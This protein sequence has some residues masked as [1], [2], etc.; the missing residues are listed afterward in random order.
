MTDWR[1]NKSSRLEPRPSVS[2]AESAGDAGRFSC[3]PRCAIGS[4]R[5]PETFGD[6]MSPMI[7]NV[8]R[9]PLFNLA[10]VATVLTFLGLTAGWVRS[11]SIRDSVEYCRLGGGRF[12][13]WSGDGRV[14]LWLQHYDWSKRPDVIVPHIVKSSEPCKSVSEESAR[15]AFLGFGFDS[16]LE[17]TGIGYRYVLVPYWFLAGASLLLSVCIAR[18]SPPLDGRTSGPSNG[19]QPFRS[20]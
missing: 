9:W 12:R 4:G 17:G 3:L 1:P 16:G 18:E 5:S 19:N 14:M 11:Y 6:C 7:R 15:I 10:R 8:L 20:E 13:F 2:V